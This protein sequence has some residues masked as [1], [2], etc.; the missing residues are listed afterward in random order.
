M[1]DR[2]RRIGDSLYLLNEKEEA[3][4]LFFFVCFDGCEAALTFPASDMETRKQGVARSQT[5]FFLV[6]TIGKGERKNRHRSS[7]RAFGG[8]LEMGYFPG[9]VMVTSL[10]KKE[11]WMTP[12]PQDT[13]MIGPTG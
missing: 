12:G 11:T 3:R 1:L 10:P 13:P 7:F 4:H 8:Y 5:Y 2:G 9:S 6:L